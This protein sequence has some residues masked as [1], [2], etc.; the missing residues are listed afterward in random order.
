MT[1][2]YVMLVWDE[3]QLTET[4]DGLDLDL[5]IFMSGEVQQ[6]LQHFLLDDD[7]SESS[8]LWVRFNRS[9]KAHDWN[10][11]RAAVYLASALELLLIII[12]VSAE[13]PHS[14]EW[15]QE[16]RFVGSQG[17]TGGVLLVL[18][19]QFCKSSYRKIQ[20]G[21]EYQ[22]LF[23]WFIEITFGVFNALIYIHVKWEWV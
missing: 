21:I 7:L 4:Y 14:E 10:S 3:E 8:H 1:V 2:I 16:S 18:G 17:D 22:L 5:F 12:K 6:K 20:I 13:S 15:A 23:L 9:Q 19:L 11:L